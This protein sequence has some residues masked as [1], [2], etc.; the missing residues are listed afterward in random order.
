[1]KGRGALNLVNVDKYIGK[2]N[3]LHTGASKHVVASD[4]RESLMSRSIR[5]TPANITDDLLKGRDN[6]I[7]LRSSYIAASRDYSNRDKLIKSELKKTV[8]TT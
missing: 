4:L 1:M 3:K 7:M 8:N 6:D 2:I 5:I